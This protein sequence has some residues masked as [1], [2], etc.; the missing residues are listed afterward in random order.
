MRF[1]RILIKL[2]NWIGD[3]VMAS[4]LV[5]AVRTHWPRAQLAA[6]CRPGLRAAAGRIPGFNEVL[7]EGD[8]GVLE[9]ARALRP[10]DWD[11]AFTLSSTLRAPAAFAAAGIPVRIGFSGGGRGAFLTASIPPLPRS[12]HLTSHYLA[13]GALVGVVRPDRPRLAWT[14]RRAD[15]LEARRFLKLFAE[16]GDR[17]V[18]MCPGAAFGPAKR[19][20][21]PRWAALGDRLALGR[22]WRAVIVGG[23]AERPLGRR[24]AGLMARRPVDA[25][26][27]L[28]LG[29]TAALLRR[30]R[31]FV[32]NDSGLMHIG[33]AVGVRTVGIFGSTNPRWTGPLGAGH[34]ALWGRVPCAPCYR[35]TCL[36]GKHYA[37]FDA[38]TVDR[39]AASVAA[40]P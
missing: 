6:L 11:I 20:F 40:V 17:L 35:R 7:D 13:L 15:D 27:M 18:A 2:P 4:P 28:S 22:G 9:L 3:A 31:A 29:G 34:E 38:L 16:P 26:G 5:R 24:I 33:A 21:A 37:C 30:C 12:V 10:G 32:S 36:P 1:P 25:T 14:V 8:G 39:V 19:W 23:E